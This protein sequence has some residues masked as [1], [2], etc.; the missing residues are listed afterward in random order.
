MNLLQKLLPSFLCSVIALGYAPAWLHV[1]VCHDHHASGDACVET[2]LSC[3]SECG[4]AH[5][6]HDHQLGSEDSDG[7]PPEHDPETCLVCQS[8]GSVNGLT[9]RW[10]TPLQCASLG[11][12]ISINNKV[13]FVGPSLGI[14]HPRGPPSLS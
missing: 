4:H 11:E 12:P 2:N 10:E 1:S 3:F 13:K 6:S 5:D 9:F 8:L 14:A 7:Q